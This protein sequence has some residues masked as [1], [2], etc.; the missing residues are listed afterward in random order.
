[1]LRRREVERLQAELAEAREQIIDLNEQY[2]AAVEAHEDQLD[3]LR[4]ELNDGNS[5]DRCVVRGIVR[6][7]DRMPIR[8]SQYV[9]SV[10]V[11]T[12]SGQRYDVRRMQTGLTTEV[13]RA[14]VIEIIPRPVEDA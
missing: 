2:L 9:T 7:V 12:A 1:M 13:G 10:V 11:E 14:V 3:A 6:S 4:V 8:N 5:L